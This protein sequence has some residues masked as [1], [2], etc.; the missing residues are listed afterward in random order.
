[1]SH[2]SRDDID[3]RQ[4]LLAALSRWRSARCCRKL[5]PEDHNEDAAN[6]LSSDTYPTLTL[7][8]R[9]NGKKFMC[10]SFHANS[11]A[12]SFLFT[13]KLIFLMTIDSCIE[14]LPPHLRY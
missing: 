4:L 7:R 13:R 3:D 9:A 14:K 5:M 10:A 8:S 6:H 11:Y 12:P 1:M 2:K